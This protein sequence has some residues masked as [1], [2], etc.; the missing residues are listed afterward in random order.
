MDLFPNLC[1]RLNLSSLGSPETRSWMNTTA[2]K[3]SFAADK[4]LLWTKE[5]LENKLWYM[6]CTLLDHT[7][8]P[9][10]VRYNAQR[11]EDLPVQLTRRNGCMRKRVLQQRMRWP[12]ILWRRLK[13][14]RTGSGLRRGWL[15][16]SLRMSIQNVNYCLT[17][18]YL[19]QLSNREFLERAII[20]YIGVILH[21]Y[22][23]LRPLL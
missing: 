20:W 22:T 6:K 5:T 8:Q 2:D 7:H 14:Q 21:L 17:S 3:K 10:L 1:T 9:P 13:R 19:R 23:I 18:Q 15:R 12:Q 11:V 16:A 4:K